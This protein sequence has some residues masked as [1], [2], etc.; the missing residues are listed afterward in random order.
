MK[1]TILKY[2]AVAAILVSLGACEKNLGTYNHGSGLN[3][4]YAVAAD[5][6]LNV[7]F[8]YSPSTVITDTVW[9]NFQTIGPVVGSDRHIALEQVPSGP[10]DAIPGVHYV[11]FDDL[12]IKAYYKVPA[13]RTLT[14]IPVILKRD[15][16]LKTTITSLKIRIKPNE[17]FT[18]SY[19]GRSSVRITFND[20]LSK[21]NSWA[22]YAVFYLLGNY[23]AVK[24]QWLIEQTSEM[25]DDEYLRSIGFTPTLPSGNFDLQYITYLRDELRKKLLAHNALLQSQGKAVLKEADGTVVAF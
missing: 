7:P 4:R 14:S 1:S 9:L 17:N 3:F 21:P 23:G 16:S 8:V 13:G 22:T 25:W 20:F 19:P 6:L 5:T 10:N 15:L 18:F 11:P 24:H 12:S 2:C